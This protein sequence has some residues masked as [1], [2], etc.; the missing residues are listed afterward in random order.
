MLE[1]AADEVGLVLILVTWLH[2]TWSNACLKY[3]KAGVFLDLVFI[4]RYYLGS[5]YELRGFK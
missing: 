2:Y 4:V 3:I 5:K 1:H